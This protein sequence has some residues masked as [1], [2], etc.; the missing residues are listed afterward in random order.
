MV[1]NKIYNVCGIINHTYRIA[2]IIKY[3]NQYYKILK[4]VPSVK[5]KRMYTGFIKV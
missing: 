5:L 1:N 4:Y 2:E 3:E